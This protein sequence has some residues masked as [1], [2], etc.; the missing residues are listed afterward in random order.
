M[1]GIWHWCWPVHW[2]AVLSGAKDFSR[3]PVLG[4]RMFNRWGL[5]AA[6]KRLAKWCCQVRR[7]WLKR[8]LPPDE[9]R[10][11]D[12]QG[13]LEIAGFLPAGALHSVL[14]E[15]CAARLHF[16]ELTQPPTLT[17]RVYLDRQTC[18]ALLPTLAS[19]IEDRRL[20]RWMQYA[21]GYSG[22]PL[23]ALQCIHAQAQTDGH[24]P[25]G[26]WHC[27]TFHS[28]SKAWLF[29]HDV[30]PDDGPLGYMAGS[31]L[32]NKARMA[33]EQQQSEAAASHPNVLH[34][35]GSFRADE[36]ELQAMGYARRFTA[37][38]PR[39]TLVVADTS[40][41]HRR[42]PSLG[43]S[44]R[45]EVYLSL[46]RNPFLAGLYPSALSLPVIRRRWGQL[47]YGLH[48]LQVRMGTAAW[49]PAGEQTLRSDE[50]AALMG[51]RP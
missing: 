14:D 32:Q 5:H 35:R 31:H 29:L 28:T 33:W 39:N 43:C 21:A 13:Y 34:A 38:V 15:L 42:T 1:R 50:I 22:V 16:V 45:V 24:D 26:D 40:G 19:V 46:R 2:L 36:G 37:A 48:Q 30:A 41:F 51:P 17:R 23:I 3:N 4:S 27:D 7:L 8:G 11:F 49:R 9:L 25:Q 18:Q 6:R 10:R 44:V 20:R 47:A 12:E